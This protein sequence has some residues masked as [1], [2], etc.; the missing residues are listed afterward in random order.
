MTKAWPALATRFWPLRV[1]WACPA[2]MVKRSSWRGWMCS[3]TTPPGA[4]AQ[5]K[6]TCCPSLSSAMAV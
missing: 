4:L 5:W 1:K 6:R 2:A 3:A